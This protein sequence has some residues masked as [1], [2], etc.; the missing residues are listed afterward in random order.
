MRQAP[1]LLLAVSMLAAHL[2]AKAA[3]SSPT[4]AAASQSAVPVALPDVQDDL[5][6]YEKL[7]PEEL[8]DHKTRLA[9]TRVQV[10]K[11]E[12]TLNG[13][14]AEGRAGETRVSPVVVPL[15]PVF[16]IAGLWT[17][18]SMTLGTRAVL[19]ARL[20]SSRHTMAVGILVTA[21][22]AG[23]AYA[24]MKVDD[25]IRITNEQAI[26]LQADLRGLRY[27]LARQ[28]LL[29]SARLE[30][31]EAPLMT[32]DEIF[33]ATKEG[34]S[35][36]DGELF[37]TQSGLIFDNLR[38]GYFPSKKFTEMMNA[39]R[40]EATAETFTFGKSKARLYPVVVASTGFARALNECYPT[41]PRAQAYFRESVARSNSAG[42]WFASMT[43]T[44]I[45]MP[46]M[47]W[48]SGISVWAGRAINLISWSS[49]GVA[50]VE[51]V[52]A[53]RK[54]SAAVKKAQQECD[55]QGDCVVTKLLE[56][57]AFGVQREG[58]DVL[59][60]LE[61][62]LAQIDVMIASSASEAERAEWQALK[63]RFELLR[64]DAGIL[65]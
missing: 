28:D 45:T 41:Y 17:V 25:R 24:L 46:V 60:A 18:Q 62:D 58:Y 49:V 52:R 21:V 35:T 16:A 5:R 10:Q 64:Q 3:S 65:R 50:A 40:R 19:V 55:R 44:G 37:T 20:I 57:S 33:D 56:D 8:L 59:A 12:T 4:P 9:E 13:Q 6:V 23:G 39:L 42:R 38:A 27:E 51:R 47:G 63:R 26:R 15:S 11:L 48:I 7:T 22:T 1:A 34:C 54:S 29:V 61:K 30:A 31:A 2:P 53:L 36:L 32:E 14:L 43:M